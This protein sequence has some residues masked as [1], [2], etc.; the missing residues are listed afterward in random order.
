MP[1]APSK[2]T[3]ILLLNM[4]GPD[5]LEAVQPFLFNLFS[6][7]DIIK[8]PL[9]SVFQ[10]PLAHQI[11]TKREKTAQDNYALMGG[12]SP[13]LE[14]SL[15]QAKALSKELEKRSYGSLSSYVAMR[16]WHPFTEETV[17]KIIEDGIERLIVLPLY[18]HFSYT[19]TGSSL[20]ELQRI[21]T[22]RN[23][24]IELA[25][26][27][28]YYDHPQ[29]ISAIAENIQTA[30]DTET[31]GCEKNNVTL[32][33]SAHS[34]PIKHV[35]KTQDPYPDQIYETVR[36]V[37][38]TH[39]PDNPWELAY[40]S[41]VGNMPWL[42]PSTEGILHYFSGTEQDNLLMVAVSFVSD[43]VETLVEIDR[44]YIPLAHELEIQYCHRAPALNVNQSFINALADITATKLDTIQELETLS[45]SIPDFKT[46]LKETQHPSL[47]Y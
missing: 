7:P 13:I 25:V 10:K 22:A 21:L 19:T 34:L 39:F 28:A 23:C 35:K 9:S 33:F 24:S 40:Q 15:A 12:A 29:Y 11:S 44:E 30:L 36:L 45:C 1:T 31:W 17:A 4:G 8:L 6:D 20:N 27:P 18:P 16:Y 43:H 42:G 38:E 32:V 46:L 37:A 2:K 5:S 3:G 41:Q 14:Y 26:I 47:S